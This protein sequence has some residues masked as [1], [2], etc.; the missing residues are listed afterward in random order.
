MEAQIVETIMMWVG[1]AYLI[2]VAVALVILAFGMVI[3]AIAESVENLRKQ[4]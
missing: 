2:C 3:G 1:A 4:W